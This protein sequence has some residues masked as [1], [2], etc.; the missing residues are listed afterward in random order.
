MLKLSVQEIIKKIEAEECFEAVHEDY[1]FQLKIDR[2]VPYL[3]A[4][5][6]NGHQFRKELW[7]NCFHTEYE[8]W[9]EEDPATLEMI[10]SHPILIHGLD[11]RF[12]YDLN[13][14]P[15]KAVY[16]D[17]WGKQ[18]WRN[19]LSEDQKS[20]S[21]KK[22]GNFYQVV[23]ALIAKLEEKFGHVVA[24]DMHSYNWERWNRPV[25]TFNIGSARVDQKRFGES[26]EEWRKCLA[27]IELPHGIESSST[28]NDVFQ[29]NGYF[30]QF[31]SQN[32]SNTLVLATEVKKVYCDEINQVIFP[33]V[34]RAIA[35]QLSIGISQHAKSF[36]TNHSN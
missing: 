18:L 17:A 30:L 9:Y 23:H 19:P 8:R 33:E 24:Y 3:C 29:G 35:E 2:Y 16:S 15:E 6:H 11:S 28:I 4:A 14:A 34:V 21:L 1:G 10:Q 31:I 20:H 13:R 36:Y 32:F 22:H 7:E 5:I 26:I 25:P 27:N 12:E